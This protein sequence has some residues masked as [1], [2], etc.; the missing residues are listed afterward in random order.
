MTENPGILL[1]ILAFVLVIG[2]LVFIHEMGHYLVGR[3]FGVHAEAFSIG[4]GRE[5]HGWTDKRGTRWKIGWMPLGGYVKFAGDMSPA[6]QTSPEWLALPPEEKARTFQAKP[7]W[8]RA[9][10]VFAG[11]AVNFLFALLV[12]GAFAVA[13][14]Q[15]QTPPVVEKLI[16]GSAAERGGIEIGDRIVAIDGRAMATFND[17]A[18]YIQYRPAMTVDVDIVRDGAA[19][20][21]ALQTGVR[22]ETDRFGNEYKIGALGIYS[23]RPVIVPVSI[24]EAPAVAVERTGAILRTM[25]DTLGQVLTGR[26]SAKELGGPLRIAQVSGEQVSQGFENFIFFV[27]LISI[28][29]GFINLLPVPM[30]DGGHLLFYAIEAIRRKPLGVAAQEWAFRSGLLVLLSLMI[31]VTINDLSSFKV[32]ERLSGLIG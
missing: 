2:P 24:V 30:L 8:Q 27:A 31:F 12:L 32:W 29:L 18:G 1:T 23:P 22:I 10:I 20:R 4:F 6:G 7:V 11:P 16:A 28:N 14:G 15:S 21:I 25:V 5:I 19:D 17:I 26:R 3:F 13:Y 9:L